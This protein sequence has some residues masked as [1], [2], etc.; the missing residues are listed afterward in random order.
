MA[1]H[2]ASP[3]DKPRPPCHPAFSSLERWDDQRQEWV[4]VAS[5]PV[6]HPSAVTIEDEIDQWLEV[7][8]MSVKNS[9]AGKYR[10]VWRDAEGALLNASSEIEV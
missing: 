9:P 10:A 3:F 7:R 2:S 8:H 5:H 4:E 1:I 6:R